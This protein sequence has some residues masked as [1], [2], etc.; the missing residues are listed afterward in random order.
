MNRVGWCRLTLKYR[1]CAPPYTLIISL[2]AANAF[3]NMLPELHLSASLTAG[4]LAKLRVSKVH[5]LL[6]FISKKLQR[7][8]SR[9][10]AKETGIGGT[11]FTLKPK[12][13]AFPQLYGKGDGLHTA[14][15]K[16]SVAKKAI[17]GSDQGF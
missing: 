1:Q 6:H 15:L 3:N 16:R 12:N 7:D 10:D 11:L 4:T 8:S 2:G 17:L 13:L 14:Y 5:S 9:T